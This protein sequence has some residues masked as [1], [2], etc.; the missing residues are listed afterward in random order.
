MQ[1][2]K[3]SYNEDV[4]VSIAA[5]LKKSIIFNSLEE[6]DLQRITPMFEKRELHTGDIITTAGNTAQHFFILEKGTL[7]LAMEDDKSVVLDSPG[8]FIAMELLSDRGMYK[9]T[10]TALEDG[11]VLIIPRE[12]FLDLIQEDTPG[13]AAIMQAWQRFLDQTAAFAKN[14]EDIDIPAIF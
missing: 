13:A 8:D 9:T 6:T 2:Y 7:L 12:L 14:I 3:N 4:M 11:V 5:V 10:I 1:Q